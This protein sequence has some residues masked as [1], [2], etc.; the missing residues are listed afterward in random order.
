MTD[1]VQSDEH[2]TPLTEEEARE[3]IPSL[4]TRAELNLAE[5]TNILKARRWAMHPRT[6]A[7]EDL[8]TDAFGRELHRRMF[9]QIWTWAGTYRK[10]E[11][12][13]GWSVP[14]L[15]EGVYH[16]FAD[17][18][19]WLWHGTYSLHESAVRLHH[20]LVCV[21][22]WPNGNGRHARLMAD[23]LVRSRGGD[24]LTWGA[25]AR[26]ADPHRLRRRYIEC[27][28]RADEGD[29]APL[30]RFARG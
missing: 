26:P 30:L 10:T 8:I 12:N 3:L 14:R 24:E 17:A 15:T 29:V 23:V 21:H 25:G 20:R 6:L 4:S 19:A 2:E 5:R 28:R 22:P 27:L 9:D 1:L 16:A 11:R 7:R 18:R 13:L